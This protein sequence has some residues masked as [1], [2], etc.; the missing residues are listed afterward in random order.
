MQVA[1]AVVLAGDCRGSVPWPSLGL[2]ARQLAPVANRPVLFHHLDALARA[3]VREAAIVTDAT[4]RA[5]IREALGD[6]AQWGLDL[7]HVHHDGSRN[8]L[9]SE[10][11]CEFVGSSPVLVHHGD[12]LLR[13]RLSALEGDFAERDLDALILRP[14]GRFTPSAGYIIGPDVHPS[15]RRDGA[16]L[17]DVLQ[18][19]RADG[20]RIGVREVDACMPCRR[21]ADELLSANRRMLEQLEPG[22]RGERV[23]DSEIQGTVDIHPSAEV[24]ASLIRGPVAIGPRARI[25]NAYV[26][27][28]TSIG[29]GVE[30]E[31]VEI[32]HSIILDGARIRFLDSRVEGS[33]VGPRADVARDF[34][35]PRAVRLSIG[36]GTRVS[37]S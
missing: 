17:D 4:T 24:R 18:R 10:P 34:S 9:A 15:L 32:E 11:I 3:G 23:F 31:C 29:A 5:S 2:A 33:L 8:V 1:K 13:E 16:A 20:A 26:G 35:L 21:G 28:Y 19:L 12:I 36:E 22:H 30:I 14:S 37:F 7:T 25:S 27:P 6:G